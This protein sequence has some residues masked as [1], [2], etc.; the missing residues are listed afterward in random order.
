[1][2]E[3]IGAN[4]DIGNSASLGYDF[5]EELSSYGERIYNVHIKDRVLGG[6]T[7]EFGTGDSNING[8]LKFL[9]NLLN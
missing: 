2:G 6:T 1:M 5:E 4:Y 7:V 9:S 8:V 3:R